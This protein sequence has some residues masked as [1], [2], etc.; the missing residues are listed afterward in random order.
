M[1][2]V[3]DAGINEIT[4]RNAVRHCSVCK[5][6]RVPSVE[7]GKAFVTL[8]SEQHAGNGCHP[9]ADAVNTRCLRAG[10]LAAGT[11]YVHLAISG[12]FLRL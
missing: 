3:S 10:I 4:A 7:Q 12:L 1:W 5:G 2:H 6:V 11:R 8:A 9:C